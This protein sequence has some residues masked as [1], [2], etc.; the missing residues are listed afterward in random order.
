[1]QCVYVTCPTTRML[2]RTKVEA[3]PKGL[4]KY[5]KSLRKV[6]CPHCPQ[7]HLI[8]IRQAYL[9]QAIAE[10]DLAGAADERVELK[11]VAS[12]AAAKPKGRQRAS[13]SS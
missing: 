2:V 1:M 8:N 4:A 11:M 13:S 9:D 10:L 5:W 6:A 7:T 12:P 3:S